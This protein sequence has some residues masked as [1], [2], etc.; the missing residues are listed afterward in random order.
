MDISKLAKSEMPPR[1]NILLA[2]YSLVV[3]GVTIIDCKM[4]CSFSRSIIPPMKNKPNTDGSVNI[5]YGRE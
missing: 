2:I 4:P 3:R 5:I 1:D